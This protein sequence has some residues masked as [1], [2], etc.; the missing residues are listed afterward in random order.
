MTRMRGQ[1][2]ARQVARLPAAA[3]VLDQQRAGLQPLLLDGDHRLGGAEG[4][5]RGA[6]DVQIV[7][8]ARLV[9][10]QGEREGLAGGLLGLPALDDLDLQRVQDGELVLHALEGAQHGLAVDRHRRVPLGRLRAHRRPALAEVEHRFGDRAAH[11]PVVAGGV[12]QAPERGGGVLALVPAERHVGI[13]GRLRDADQGVGAVHLAFGRGDVGAA[14]QQGGGKLGRRDGNR[15]RQHVGRRYGQRRRRDA[16]QHRDRVL[17]LGASAGLVGQAGLRAQQQ[18][19]GGEHVGARDV[20]RLVLVVGQGDVAPVLG[21]GVAQQRL[22]GVGGAEREIVL[23]ELALS[24]Q[25]CVDDVGRIGLGDGRIALDLAADAAPEVRRPACLQA[26]AVGGG[27]A[28]R[29]AAADHRA[30]GGGGGEPAAAAG[31]AV[32]DR[33]AGREGG[34]Q[35]GPRLG[36]DLARLAIA[37]DELRHVLVGDGHA[38]LQP[39]EHRVGIDRPPGPLVDGG[40]GLARRPALRFLELGRDRGAGALIGR[41]DQAGGG[42]EGQGDCAK[43]LGGSQGLHRRHPQCSDGMEMCSRAHLGTRHS[44]GMGAA[45]PLRR[46]RGRRRGRRWFRRS[47]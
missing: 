9:L 47:R 46:P 16:D 7:D 35:G 45:P 5:G 14:L 28:S 30:A 29:A 31:L 2:L 21:D 43:S 20:A 33:A 36:H 37:G 40:C 42:G 10:V 8:G 6:D 15:G 1:G 44:A 22:L 17:V 23:G 38:P 4:G 25:A 3:E 41:P 11:R 24:G 19:L 39:V 18:G 34:E 27:R 26:R 12:E 32:L 13:E